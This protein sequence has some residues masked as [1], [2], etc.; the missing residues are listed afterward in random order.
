MTFARTVLGDVDISA[1][2][3]TL[4]H[5]H[6][7][8]DSPVIVSRWP[9]IHL[10]SVEEAVAETRLCVAAGVKTMVDA[11]PLGS[12]GDVKG[13]VEISRATGVNLVASTGMHTAKY[14]EGTE[15]ALEARVEDLVARF[16]ADILEGSGGHRAG[17]LKVATTGPNPTALEQRVFEAA[18]ATHA[19]TGAPILTHCEGGEG[20]MEQLELLADLGVPLGR[21][22]MSHTDKVTDFRYHRDLL[23]SGV[24]LCYDQALRTPERTIDLVVAMVGRGFGERLLLGTDGARRSLWATLGG[25]PGL[26]WIVTGFREALKGRGLDEDAITLLYEINPARHLAFAV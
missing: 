6:L 16:T 18:A 22:A 12:G 24:T 14:Y 17:I 9:H 21:V 3:M 7:I 19:E 26:A 25:A 8:I 13:L 2:G 11:M 20:G 5:E 23:G 10:P 1:L 4:A 15:G